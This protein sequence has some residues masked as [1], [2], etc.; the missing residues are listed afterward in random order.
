[1]RRKPQ[2]VD[3]LQEIIRD[4][5]LKLPDRRYLFMYNTPEMQIMREMGSL[6]LVAKKQ[7]DHRVMREEVLE[8]A[9]DTDGNVPDIAHVAA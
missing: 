2:M 5:K 8:A 6:E 3:G 1:M 9:G 4:A 7:Q